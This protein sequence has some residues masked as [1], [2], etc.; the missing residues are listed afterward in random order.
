MGMHARHLNPRRRS[1]I[2]FRALTRPFFNIH[3]RKCGKVELK[4][5]NYSPRMHAY[6]C[7]IDCNDAFRWAESQGG[8]L[9]R[10]CAYLHPE[11][12][13]FL[14]RF[15]GYYL[16]FPVLTSNPFTHRPSETHPSL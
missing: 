15:T 11:I 4:F 1:P 13:V 6:C 10:T 16:R 8:K 2:P 7:C 14:S 12:S 5:F 3:I 9:N